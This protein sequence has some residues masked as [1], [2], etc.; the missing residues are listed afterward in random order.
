[1]SLEYR[2]GHWNVIYWPT[3]RYGRKARFAIPTE[4]QDREAA[5]IWHDN[6]IDDWKARREQP[7]EPHALTDLTIGQLWEE[8]MKWS[9]L[10]HAPTTH[11]DLNGGGESKG[12]V[13]VGQWVKKYIGQYDAEGLGQHHCQIYQ[14]M[15]TAD[16]GRPINRTINKELAYL[17]GMVKWASEYKHITPRKLQ[18][19]RLPYKRPLPQ[20]LTASE[21][22]AIIKN[23]EPFYRAYF[24]C[25]YALGLRSIE[26]R[27]LKWKDVNFERRVVN[28]IQKGGSTKSLPMGPAVISSFEAIAPPK[29]KRE[30][31]WDELP[32]FLNPK[33]GKA[34][35]FIRK[36]IHRACKKARIEKRVTPHMLRHSCATHMLDAGVNLRVIQ[37]FLGHSNIQTTEIYTHVSLENLRAAQS[38]I[39]GGFKNKG[40]GKGA[41]IIQWDTV[42]K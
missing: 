16:A 25:L 20:V 37:E 29:G 32:V 8:Y 36:A 26:A 40:Y 11:L 7:K 17:G 22:L 33:K 13:G 18:I 34:V 9:E 2:A 4:I 21:V 10:H 1:M 39:S 24:V 5:L 19:D 28:M 14:R 31:G 27:N 15:R 41:E 12:K 38:L 35:R 6:F 30:A 23:A 42:K 3:G